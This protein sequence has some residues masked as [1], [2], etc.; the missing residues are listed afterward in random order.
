MERWALAQT[1][2]VVSVSSRYTDRIRALDHSPNGRLYETIYSGFDKRLLPE[3]SGADKKG[4]GSDFVDIL[5]VGKLYKTRRAD[6][7]VRALGRLK[8]GDR[9]ASPRWRLTFLGHVAAD[10]PRAARLSRGDPFFFTRF[11]DGLRADAVFLG[12]FRHGHLLIGIG[13]FTPGPAPFEGAAQRV[14]F[15]GRD[16]FPFLRNE[17]VDLRLVIVVIGQGSIDLGGGEIVDFGNFADRRALYL[18]FVDDP[19]YRQPPPSNARLAPYDAGGFDDVFDCQDGC[20]RHIYS[21]YAWF[22]RSS[23]VPVS[24]RKCNPSAIR[25]LFL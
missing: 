1:E 24:N 4:D 7:L 9:L 22:F 17:P 23:G 14:A 2:A 18:V 11:P 13:P 5:C 25:L 12:D 10:Q 8:A 19:V 21:Q 20:L 16:E 3:D 15:W 6:E